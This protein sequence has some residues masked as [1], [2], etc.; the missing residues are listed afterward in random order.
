MEDTMTN[1]N[2]R[3]ARLNFLYQ[4]I[5]GNDI[6][7]GSFDSRIK[8][9]KLVYILKSEG[10]NLGYDFTWYIR[11][12]YSSDLADD[13]FHF[14]NGDGMI[15]KYNITDED[16]TV[17]DRLTRV[18]HLIRDSNTAELVASFLFLKSN[19]G[20]GTAQELMTRKPRFTANQILNIMSEWYR[21][22]NNQLAS[23]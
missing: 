14:S 6:D 1:I 15:P 21:A 19:Y 4:R 13:G 18:T 16:R 8:L 22:T 10:I 7:M 17:L 23:P 20:N 5:F 3:L 2:N 9:Q 12:P 11:G